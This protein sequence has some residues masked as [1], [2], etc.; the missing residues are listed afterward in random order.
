MQWDSSHGYSAAR[1]T[2]SSERHRKE[3]NACVKQQLKCGERLYRLNSRAGWMLV[4]QDQRRGQWAWHHSGTGYRQHG[5]GEEVENAPHNNFFKQLREVSGLHTLFVWFFFTWDIS[6]CD[7]CRE[8]NGT[9]QAMQTISPGCQGLLLDAGTEWAK[10]G[11]TLL[12]LLFINKK[13]GLWM[14]YFVA[15]LAVVTVK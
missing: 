12:D 14:L 3:E 5:R 2:G 11:D 10:K 6:F 8:Q 1:D 13:K 7:T 9:A 4:G 15:G